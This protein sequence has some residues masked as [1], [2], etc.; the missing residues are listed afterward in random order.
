MNS[1]I[2]RVAFLPIGFFMNLMKLSKV[3]SRD[4]FN[5]TRFKGAMI[6]EGCCINESSIIS[7]DTHI[8]KNC[9]I[10]N[11]SINSYSYIGYNSLVQNATIGKFCSIANDVFIGLGKHPTDQISTSTLFYRKRNTLKIQ[12]VDKD[13]DFKEYENIRIGNDVWIG[14]RAIIMDGITIG[15]GAIIAAN[16]VVTKDVP[17]YGIVGGVPAKV[18]KFRFSEEKIAE[19]Q[20]LMWWNWPIEQIRA[21]LIE[22]QNII[23]C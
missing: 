16:S 1:K 19:L 13:L 14:A 5:K 22:L 10:N 17:P 3:G 20:Q 6:D 12:L 21:R 4:L 23:K 15:N 9:T 11:S 18:I 2:A 7:K 8:L